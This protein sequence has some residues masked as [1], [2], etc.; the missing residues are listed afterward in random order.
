MTGV[1]ARSESGQA[2]VVMALLLVVLIGMVGLAVD[3]GVGYYYNSRAERAAAAGALSG[4]VFMPSQFA[5]C[6]GSGDAVDRALAETGHNGFTTGSASLSG[7]SYVATNSSTHVTVTVSR[8]SS[9][10]QLQ[11]TVA[12]DI[13]S[14]FLAAFGISTVHIAR[15]AIAGYLAPI[16]LGQ[17]GSQL[18]STVSQLGTPSTNDYY[19]MRTEGWS[20][21]KS[22]GDAYTPNPN[23]SSDVH[24]ISTTAGNEV[25]DSTLPA[26]GGYNYQV[27]LPRGGQIQVYNAAFAPERTHNYCENVGPPQPAQC[28]TH[29]TNYFLHEDD[30]F[31]WSAGATEYSAMRYTVYSVSNL[32]LHSSDVK[33]SQVTVLP[34]D[35]SNARTAGN[36]YLDVNRNSQITQTYDSQGNPSN[37]A[38]YHSWIPITTYAGT[39][40]RSP[41]T[42]SLV[43]W[44]TGPLTGDLPPGTYR[45]RIDTLNYDGSLPPGGSHAHKALAVRLA[46]PN[47]T[48]CSTG[49]DPCIVGS[50]DDMAIYTPVSGTSF[51][52]PLFQMPPSYAGQ[53]VDVDIYDPGDLNGN[54]GTA[55][56]NII[57]ASTGSPATGSGIKIY[58]LG[59]SRADPPASP[60]GCSMGSPV[61]NPPCLVSS[62]GPATFPLLN[63]SGQAYFNGHWVRVEIPIAATYN[64]TGSPS[65][66]FWQLRYNTTASVQAVDTVT[67]TVSLRGAPAHLLSS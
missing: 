46:G 2:I 12:Q 9:S 17:P 61:T 28:N 62:G 47:G 24:N 22:E 35:A 37:M 42:P 1:K 10:Q 13:P 34:I 33:L 3:I 40:D 66:W 55:S 26:R 64:P 65:S 5:P 7:G 58:D 16:P 53:T 23:G 63:S 57:D 21:P 19:F 32:F 25:T 51:T 38:I 6:C 48:A 43:Q 20:T 29:G 15:T 52:I 27:F 18:G 8:T 50:W 11:V 31:S 67:V 44:N 30:S 54:G 14:T 4:V 39:N 59:G 56:M 60:A 45:L 36:Q 49:P 41:T